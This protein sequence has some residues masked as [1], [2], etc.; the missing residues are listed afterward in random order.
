MEKKNFHELT[1]QELLVEKKKMKKSKI[2]AAT[3]IGFLAGVFIFGMV[4]WFLSEEKRIGFFIPML[5]PVFFIYKMIKNPNVNA[6]LEEVL[7]QRNL[8]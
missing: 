8:D 6:E 5:I 4:G 1:D 2:F 7:K 3:A